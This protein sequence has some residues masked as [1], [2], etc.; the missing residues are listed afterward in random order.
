MLADFLVHKSWLNLSIKVREDCTG[1]LNYWYRH[2]SKGGWPFSTPDNGW[3]V[4]DCT[5]EGLK[6]HFFFPSL[7]FLSL[8]AM[9]ACG[10]LLI[11]PI[12]LLTMERLVRFMIIQAAILLSQLPAD[13][14]GEAIQEN[15][16]YDAVN[17]ILSLQVLH[18]QRS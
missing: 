6:V 10:Y 13:I 16:L 7:C 1:D 11:K 15:Q 8:D 18:R 4:S 12:K 14:V 2:I 17:V 5:A 9:L 3:P